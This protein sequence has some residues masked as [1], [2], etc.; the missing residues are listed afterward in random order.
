[1]GGCT[2]KQWTNKNSSIAIEWTTAEAN[3]N[4]FIAIE[5][6]TAVA[7]GVLEYIWLA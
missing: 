5:Q 1:M 3:I 6:T 4:T 7:I 2:N